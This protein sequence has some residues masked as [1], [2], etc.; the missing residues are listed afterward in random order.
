MTAPVPCLASPLLP[1]CL[2]AACP[3]SVVAVTPATVAE[4]LACLEDIFSGPSAVPAALE[5]AV[6]FSLDVVASGREAL[7]GG[8]GGKGGGL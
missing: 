7:G 4:V 6:R 3:G 1:L 8:A 5:E 2:Q